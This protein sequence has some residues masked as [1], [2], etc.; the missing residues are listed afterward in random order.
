MYSV[1]QRIKNIKQPYGGFV[2]PSTFQVIQ[3]YDDIELKSEENIH[4]GLVGLTVDYMTRYLI[5]NHKEDAFSISLKGAKL[6]NELDKAYK[7][8]DQITGIDNNSIICA[9]KLVGYDVCF[10]AGVPFFKS[11]DD[12]KPDSNTI[13]NI[14]TMIN[15]GLT[16]FEKYGPII[17]DGITFE[18][19][20]TEIVSHGDGDFLTKDTLWDFKVSKLP[21]KKEHTLQLLM[22][23]LMGK[24]SIHKEFVNI[25]KIGVFNPRKNI[26]Y[27]KSISEI[28]AD[29][30]EKIEFEI[31]GY[32]KNEADQ[33]AKINTSYFDMK[34]IMRI[35]NC[36]RPMIMEYYNEYN[37]PLIKLDGQYVIRI[38]QLYI[39]MD[40]MEKIKK[41]Q[42]KKQNTLTV[43]NI[44]LLVIIAVIVTLYNL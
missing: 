20:Y 6:I 9:C 13:F 2:T 42:K 24:H 19:G 38:D 36:T 1:T 3:L 26:V 11:I 28:S 14:Q 25:T 23:Y 41:K 7:L 29:V 43:V 39:W 5:T 15:R 35:L 37:L 12:I 4:S 32:A 27:I 40:N 34:D 33:K 30:I 22:Y 44:L 18:G 21:L 16:F 31:I 8:L 10:R 17:K